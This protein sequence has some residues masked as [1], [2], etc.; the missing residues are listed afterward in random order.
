MKKEDLNRAIAELDETY[1][2]EAAEE[3]EK[4]PAV[5][6]RYGALAAALA[7]VVAG[8]LAASHFS[9][10]P[11]IGNEETGENE[12]GT[13]PKATG[14]ETS[15]V[16]VFNIYKD[17]FFY[18]GC[19]YWVQSRSTEP[20]DPNLKGEYLG[21]VNAKENYKGNESIGA[22]LY[23]VKGKNGTAQVYR[24]IDGTG[25]LFVLNSFAVK[26]FPSDKP[27]TP[28]MERYLTVFGGTGAE[29]VE[30]IVIVREEETIATVPAE[31][32]EELLTLCKGLSDDTAG[33]EAAVRA[34]LADHP[35]PRPVEQT[36]ENGNRYIP[37]YA[38]ATAAFEDGVT[39]KMTLTD[40]TEIGLLTYF[41][42]IGYA[43]LANGY[44]VQGAEI[45][46]FIE[47]VK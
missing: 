3:T 39:V 40:G 35:A 41:P 47:S 17:M 14:G 15:E 24:E 16:V 4:K 11:E 13:V 44:E 22:S 31:R 10:N 26:G 9:R 45:A 2:D 38:G 5:W 42:K 1:L 12:T 19:Y 7:V 23:R 27:Y 8:T 32:V 6:K 46:A 20:A 28:T 37:G 30:K 36:D 34:Y 25:K 18:D 43:V 33:Y 21:T 29:T